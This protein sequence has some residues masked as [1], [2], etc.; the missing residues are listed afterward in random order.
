MPSPKV[1]KPTLVKIG[2]SFIDPADVAA[3]R[4]VKTSKGKMY[5]VDRHAVPNPQFAMWVKPVDIGNLVAYFNIEGAD[6]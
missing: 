6:E 5:V 4:L 1:T 2:E 3:I